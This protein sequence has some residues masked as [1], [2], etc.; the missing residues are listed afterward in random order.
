MLIEERFQIKIALESNP[1][2][3][4]NTAGQ[5]ALAKLDSRSR[6]TVK[7][8]EGSIAHVKC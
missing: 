1:N 5:S 6:V 3:S 2:M 4:E 8:K 7:R